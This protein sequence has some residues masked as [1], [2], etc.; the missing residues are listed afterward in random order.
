MNHVESPIKNIIDNLKDNELW[1][2]ILEQIVWA[3]DVE[4]LK[5]IE[6]EITQDQTTSRLNKMLKKITIN[7]KW[8]IVFG[9]ERKDAIAQEKEAKKNKSSKKSTEQDSQA[10]E[11]TSDKY[12]KANMKIVQDAL[13]RYE[14]TNTHVQRAILA[15]IAKESWFKP[16]IPEKSYKDTSNKRIR[17]IFGARV[18]GLSDT[19][20]NTLK[21]NEQAFRDR[22]Y[23]PDDPT[24]QSQRLG[25]TQPWD[26]MKYRGRWFNGITFKSTY[27]KYGDMIGVDLVKNPELLEKPDIAA[28]VNAAYFAQWLKN[29]TIIQKYGNKWWP[30][31]F[32]NFTTALQAVININAGIAKDINSK[33]VQENYNKALAASQYINTENLA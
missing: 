5:Q 8:H 20:L 28:K 21:S 30:N 24:G 23:G 16:Q 27:K 29:P 25:N 3:S 17:E 7:I 13:T 6:Q 14:I 15:N 32:N 4:W 1:A 33:N 12:D 9:D 2:D 18:S 26:G 11:I 31:D 10:P 22:V 19:Q